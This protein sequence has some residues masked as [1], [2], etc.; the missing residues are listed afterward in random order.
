M[1][2]AMRMENPKT[3]K[4]TGPARPVEKPAAA[5]GGTATLWCFLHGASP[6]PLG[7]TGWP[8]RQGI[9]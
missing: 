6:L 7:S 3:S 1:V 9:A 8:R 2:S 4:A 5:G